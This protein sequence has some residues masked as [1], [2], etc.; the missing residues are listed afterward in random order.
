MFDIVTFIVKVLMHLDVFSQKIGF[1]KCL[2]SCCFVNTMIK[3]LIQKK[4][5][6]LQTYFK[7]KA[8][9]RRKFMIAPYFIVQQIIIL[10]YIRIRNVLKVEL[11]NFFANPKCQDLKYSTKQLSDYLQKIMF[12]WKQDILET[13]SKHVFIYLYIN[14]QH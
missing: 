10:W 11:H 4:L 9:T 7:R 14:N 13:S 6:I 12:L 2:N 5:Y 1:N 8:K 3:K